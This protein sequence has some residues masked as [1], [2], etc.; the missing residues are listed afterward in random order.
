[1][2]T[3]FCFL[4]PLFLLS[5]FCIFNSNNKIHNEKFGVKNQTSTMHSFSKHKT[6]KSEQGLCQRWFIKKRMYPNFILNLKSHRCCHVPLTWRWCN[7]KLTLS[8]CAIIMFC[9]P[10]MANHKKQRFQM[11]RI[12]LLTFHP[13]PFHPSFIYIHLPLKPCLWC[14]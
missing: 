4:H 5:S 13:C 12:S 6:F 1:M 8:W 7:C 3:L 9:A 11:E 2:N 14:K 10:K